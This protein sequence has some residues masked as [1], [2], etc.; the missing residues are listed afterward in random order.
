M[1]ARMKIPRINTTQG[2]LV[3]DVTKTATT[4]VKYRDLGSKHRK[5]NTTHFNNKSSYCNTKLQLPRLPMTSRIPT[6]PQLL[7][8]HHFQ[9][10]GSL[11]PPQRQHPGLCTT[12]HQL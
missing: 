12:L 11:S 6:S 4:I 7:P 9:T 3:R 5:S 1:R 2:D 10:Q 8:T